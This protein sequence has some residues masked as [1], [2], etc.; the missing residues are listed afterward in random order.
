MTSRLF[1]TAA[2]VLAFPVLWV[3]GLLTFSLVAVGQTAQSVRKI[4]R[5][6]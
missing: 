5:S 6:V 3:F 4:W 2:L 1:Q